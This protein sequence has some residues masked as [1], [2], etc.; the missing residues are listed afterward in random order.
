MSFDSSTKKKLLVLH[1][2]VV[3]ASNM[4][5][6]TQERNSRQCEAMTVTMA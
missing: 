3:K 2:A 4:R 6:L 1:P 5:Q